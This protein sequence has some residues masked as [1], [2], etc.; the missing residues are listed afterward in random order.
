MSLALYMD[1]NVHGAIT[2]GLRQHNV[3]GMALN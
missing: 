1:E 2:N 3:D